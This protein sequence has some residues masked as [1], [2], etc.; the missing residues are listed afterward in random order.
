MSYTLSKLKTFVNNHHQDMESDTVFGFWVY[1]MT[2][3]LIFGALFA[4]YA[5]TPAMPTAT[6]AMPKELFD[7]M[8]VLKETGL[9]L[10]SS[11][12][13]GLAMLAMYAN[14][15]KKMVSWMVVTAL[16]GLS[17]LYMEVTEFIHLVDAGA[18][19]TINAYWAAFYALIGTHGLH[20]SAGIIWMLVLFVHLKVNGLTTENK[21]RIA[22]LSLFWHFLDLIWIV[23]FTVVYLIGA[24]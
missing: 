3:C 22:C 7:L 24:L 14:N 18:P 15:V 10:A 19:I 4:V 9:L 5:V 12:T 23:V 11:F 8:F 13:F 2:D 6:G 21:T 16:L 17:F 20:V 1:L